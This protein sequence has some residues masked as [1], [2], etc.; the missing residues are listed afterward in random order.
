MYNT[1]F[2]FE[3]LVYD[4][5]LC[6]SYRTW[7]IPLLTAMLG[8]LTEYGS[9]GLPYLI[10]ILIKKIVFEDNRINLKYEHCFKPVWVVSHFLMTLLFYLYFHGEDA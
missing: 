5:L 7:L 4:H 3:S 6:H 2:T 10:Q 1:E 9:K 8:L